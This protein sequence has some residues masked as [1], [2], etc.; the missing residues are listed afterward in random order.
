MAEIVLVHGGF[1]GAWIWRKLTPLLEKAGHHV[2]AIDLPGH[3]DDTTPVEDADMVAYVNRACA[4]LDGLPEAAHLV[5][6]SMGGVVI[7]QLAEIRPEKVLSLI[8]VSALMALPG[9]AG[10]ALPPDSPLIPSRI[11][12]DD[13]MHMT[14]RTEDIGRLYFNECRPDDIAFALENMVPMN[15]DMSP[16][17]LDQPMQHWLDTPRSYITCENDRVIPI[18]LQRQMIADCRCEHVI[19]MASD[20]APF[21]SAPRDLAGHISDLIDRAGGGIQT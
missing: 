9:E 14:I 17:P 6:H 11:F 5:G 10:P 2:T 7:T 21:F 1:T 4:V 13:A 8:F 15:T 18:S 20:H 19:D 16:P 3:G 12:S